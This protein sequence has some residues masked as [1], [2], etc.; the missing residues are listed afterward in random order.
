MRSD[1]LE[2]ADHLGDAVEA[3]IPREV[4]EGGRP[5]VPWNLWHDH[6]LF[7]RSGDPDALGRLVDEYSSYARSLAARMARGNESREDLDQ[8]ALEGLVVALRRFDPDRGIPFPAFATPTILGA[9]RRHYRDHG[10]LVRVS[11]R[12]HEI[13]SAQRDAVETLTNRLEREPT[14]AEVAE[15]IGVEV[16]VLDE[17]RRA[18]QARGTRSIDSVV[19][20]GPSLGAR[21]GV[22]DGGFERCEERIALRN[23]LA[24]LEPEERSLL[25]L[26]YFEERSQ[27]DIASML[28]VSQMQVS[29]LLRSI[30]RRL[31]VRTLAVGA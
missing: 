4:A 17:A 27:A 29:R 22:D 23:A 15:A 16:R 1:L 2:R 30:V 12:V 5:S 14:E 13:A 28:G 11:R 6:V 21:L 19:D 18:L 10:W 8:L 9:L 31:R 7:A 26:Y 24:E 20:D 3:T 25:G